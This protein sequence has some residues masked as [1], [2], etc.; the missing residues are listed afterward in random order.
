M[1]NELREHD[2]NPSDG[3]VRGGP[4]EPPPLFKSWT[5]WYALVFLNLVFLIVVFSI[6][7]RIF[8]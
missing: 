5:A 1:A 7:S 3:D 6:F 4:E 2:N 8:R